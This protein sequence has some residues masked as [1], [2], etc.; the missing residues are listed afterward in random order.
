MDRIRIVPFP[1]FKITDEA[2]QRDV[3]GNTAPPVKNQK[4]NNNHAVESDVLVTVNEYRNGERRVNFAVPVIKTDKIFWA[5]FPDP[6][7]LYLSQAI[8]QYNISEHIRKEEFV[9]ASLEVKESEIYF[10]NSNSDNTSDVYNL[11]L[12]YRIGAIIMLVCSLEA[13]VNS[14]IPEGFTY[15]NSKGVELDKSETQWKVSLKEK[16]TDVIPQ[17]TSINIKDDHPR[18]LTRINQLNKTRNEFV[19]LKNYGS[20]SFSNDYHKLFRDMQKFDIEKHI[21]AIKEYMNLIKPDFI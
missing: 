11:Y 21:I 4:A 15:L 7:Q 13:F 3:K 8:D 9:E 2:F 18:L 19:H 12:Q 20:N 17:I 6:I 1:N 10:L 14:L 16:V 5:V